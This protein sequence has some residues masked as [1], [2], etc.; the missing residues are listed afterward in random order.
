M[1]LYVE[2]P[3]NSIKHTHTETNKHIQ[4]SHKVQ[5]RSTA[6][7]YTSNHLKMKLKKKNSVHNNIKK[8]IILRNKF[9]KRNAS[10]VS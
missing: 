10:L 8:Y 2:N 4:Q 1:I 5:T 9:N 6:F 3:D 7:L